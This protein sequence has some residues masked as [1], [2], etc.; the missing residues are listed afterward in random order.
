M[1]KKQEKKKKKKNSERKDG[2]VIIIMISGSQYFNLLRNMY[3]FIGLLSVCGP[4][5]QARNL[6][7]LH[8]EAKDCG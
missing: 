3:S 5:P 2:L 6:F 4:D 8:Q 1:S 7:F